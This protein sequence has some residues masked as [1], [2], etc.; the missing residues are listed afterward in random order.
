MS[1][2][3]DVMK[4]IQS[5]GQIDGMGAVQDDR[6]VPIYE[7]LVDEEYKEFIDAPTDDN[8]LQEA[9]DL[10]WVALGYCIAR[11]WDVDGAWKELTRSNMSKLQVDPATGVLKRR[12][13]GKVLKPDGWVK[14]DF[15]P[16]I[17]KME[18]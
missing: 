12:S 17:N 3:H 15:T 1:M 13:D 2:N 11:G 10:V 14:P 9:M 8:K 6:T 18:K 5:I 4:F 16:F 7:N